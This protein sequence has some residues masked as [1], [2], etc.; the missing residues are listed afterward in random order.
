MY[1]KKKQIDETNESTAITKTPEQI[2]FES[3]SV[4]RNEKLENGDFG[5][6]YRGIKIRMLNNLKRRVLFKRFCIATRFYFR[7]SS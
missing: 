5:T 6:V 4:K 7:S 3:E 2:Q 1:K